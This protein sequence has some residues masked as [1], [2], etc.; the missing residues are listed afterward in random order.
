MEDPDIPKTVEELH[1]LL[2]VE[3]EDQLTHMDEDI[4]EDNHQMVTPFQ[5]VHHMEVIHTTIQ[6]K[7]YQ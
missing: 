7:E 2:Q 3:M 6:D 4:Q 1:T 5:Q